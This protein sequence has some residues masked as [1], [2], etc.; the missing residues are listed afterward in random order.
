MQG[1]KIENSKEINASQ[2]SKTLQSDTSVAPTE[3][4]ED[5]AE[6][7]AFL[8]SSR[9]GSLNSLECWPV[10]ISSETVRVTT[11]KAIDDTELLSEETEKLHNCNRDRINNH[12]MYIPAN[13]TGNYQQNDI[14][15]HTS[16]KDRC[17]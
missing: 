10:N 4:K 7:T 15:I 16:M 3:E 11:E 9:I 6:A 14:S 17:R 8:E 2:Q 1:K 13:A 12:L 5:P